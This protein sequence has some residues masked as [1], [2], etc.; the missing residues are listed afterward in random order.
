MLKIHFPKKC[1][2]VSFRRVSKKLLGCI[3][4]AKEQGRY[5]TGMTCV[6]TQ[7]STKLVPAV[8]VVQSLS[9]VHL[10]V[11][12]WTAARWVSLSFTISW[13]L[14]KLMS[15]ES[16]MPSNHLFLCG[17]LL[18]LPS[19]VVTYSYCHLLCVFQLW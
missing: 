16:V 19:V 15:I 4:V 9:C 13:S 12:P 10:F 14:L 11:T 17:P 2:T 18:L 1:V 7:M 5:S 6:V 8:G 3:F